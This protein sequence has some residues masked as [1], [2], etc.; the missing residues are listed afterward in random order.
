MPDLLLSTKFF[1][2]HTRSGLVARPRLL[3][4]LNSAL[5]LPL[6]VI[7]APPGYGKT[8]LLAEWVLS[9]QKNSSSAALS[10]AWVSLDVDDNVLARFWT[11]TITALQRAVEVISPASTTVS[12]FSEVQGL[13]AVAPP[14][15][16]VFLTPLINEISLLPLSIVLVLDDYH[17]ILDPTI[18]ESIAY[19]VDH[20]P[21]NLHLVI[22]SRT[23][24]PLPLGRW[25]G[26]GQLS[27][28]RTQDLR[29]LLYEAVE[30]L[31]STMGLSLS[32]ELVAELDRRTEGWPAGLQMA[33]F[34]LQDKDEAGVAR[35]ITAF[36]GR[37]HF[38]LDYFTGEI[39]QRQPE[40]VQHFLLRTAVLDRMCAE[41]CAAVLDDGENPGEPSLSAA[42]AQAMLE[43]LERANLF[44]IPLDTERYWYRYHHLFKD[45][46]LARLRQAVGL[47]REAGLRRRAAQWYSRQG[48]LSEG[49]HQAL[50]AQD[51]DLAANLIE[52]PAQSI[53][54][55][56]SGEVAT[57]LQWIQQLPPE[58]IQEHLWLRLYQSRSVYFT[59]QAAASEAILDE[60]EQKIRTD[61]DR[62]HKAEVLLG[63][64]LSHRAR[65]ASVRGQVK[66]AVAISNQ[67][68]EVL[69]QT[70]MNARNFVLPTLAYSAYIMGDVETASRLYEESALISRQIGSRFGTIG[71]LSNLARTLLARGRLR[72]AIQITRQAIQEGMIQGKPL[73][74]TG[75]PHFPLAE[76][77]YEQNHLVEAEQTLLEGLRLVSE[78]QLTDYFGLMPALLAQ[79]QFSLGQVN[80]AQA[81]MEAALATAR[82]STVPMYL[83]QI[84][85]YQ[86]RLWL[87]SG[88]LAHAMRWAETYQGQPES[89]YLC[90]IE[91]MVLAETMLGAGRADEARSLLVPMG[92]D[93]Q[94]RGR[95]GREIAIRGLL[96]LARSTLGDMQGASVDLERALS[97][98]E[99]EGYL[100]PF[101][102]FGEPMA[103]LLRTLPGEKESPN[104][105][106]ARSAYIG[107]ILYAFPKRK[108]V[109]PPKGGQH[110]QL[111]E[112]LTPREMDVLRLLAEG[113]SNRG[114]AERLYLSP[115]TLRVYTTNLY[116]KLEVHN[117]TQ[118]VTRALS[119]GLI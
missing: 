95:A 13:M 6:S 108:Q 78:G 5:S 105:R 51:Y 59:G 91:E 85:A 106:D 17:V 28:L 30:F 56:E 70:E 71:T 38:L 1:I 50:Q 20:S 63:M 33:A 113:L 58:V 14:P 7:T 86:A 42:Q 22:V 18:S 66:A 98:G 15:Y 48:H 57:I 31:N 99:P 35:A 84:E 2:P 67:A 54:I 40:D 11:Y 96:A 100:R 44:V 75:W 29:F 55:W 27:S 73:P 115:N 49:I 3:K 32:Q 8:T 117:R 69:P 53:R 25:R 4:S 72:E 23:D 101:I 87:Q 10:L 21:A 116:A 65:Y 64:V 110:A 107:R 82:R 93:S 77:L 102:H 16:Q 45:L 114:I 36:S 83:S 34:T 39:L 97:L 19:L 92:E 111:V 43:H 61:P 80:A 79:I 118:A 9:L 41:L 104:F 12:V 26:R 90:E 37:H 62:V 94:A 76:A 88:E 47:D 74:V 112:P 24:P 46:L 109:V 119:L 81:M 103:G 52:S 60:I 68:L 89:E